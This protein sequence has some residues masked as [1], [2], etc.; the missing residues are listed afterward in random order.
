MKNYR[1][2][3]R[4]SNAITAR[5]LD[6]ETMVMSVGNSTVFTLDEVASVIWEAADGA[7]PLDEIVA[8]RICTQYDITL[9]VA[10]KEAEALVEDLA[11]H[12]IVLLSDQPIAGSSRSLKENP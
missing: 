8:N 4:C 1:Y 7:T 12:G 6:D 11:A 2:V 5:V 3:A 9:D 10:L